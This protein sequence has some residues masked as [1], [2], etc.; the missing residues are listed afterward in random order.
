[1]GNNDCVEYIH[2]IVLSLTSNL[3]RMKKQSF[4]NTWVDNILYNT[5]SNGLIQFQQNEIDDIKDFLENPDNYQE[6]NTELLAHF[7][8][9]GFICDASYDEMDHILFQNKMHTL[10]NKDGHLTINPTL[11]CN[12]KCWYCIVEDQ[13]TKYEHRRMDDGTIKKIKKHINYLIN[14][15]K[16]NTLHIDWFGGE[17]LMYFKEVIYPISKYGLNCCT[18]HNIPFSNHV[19]TN[20]Y[21][22]NS[23]MIKDFNKIK[24]SSFQI[25]IDGS[26]KKHN[27]V[28]NM[29]GKGHFK[30]IMESINALCEN[31]V[32]CYIILRINYDKQ[33][34]Q[35]I[36]PIIDNIKSE[37]RSKIVVDFQRVWQIPLT[38]DESGNN[39]I[40]LDIKKKF[41]QEGFQTIYFAYSPKSYRCCYADNFYHRVINYDGKVYK[42]SAC[43]YGESWIIGDINSKGEMKFKPIINTMFSDATFKNDKCLNCKKLPLCYGPCIQKYYETK[44]GKNTFHCLHEF[45]EISF[46][47]Y[48]KFLAQ[49]RL[50]SIN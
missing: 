5:L 41:E 15:D 6:N 50:S 20:A 18:E 46:E 40:L 22:I 32:N 45:S 44:I 12:Y 2:T 48:V 4:Y 47:E 37:N 36:L 1:M 24:M 34:L 19:T 9:L 3:I 11:E 16:I 23:S 8:R 14:N 7:E 17:P 27:S 13:H 31:I 29:N 21:Y 43:D 39:Q 38:T 28:K 49:K 25:P 35:T 42:C 26:E 33:T 10:H 30:Q